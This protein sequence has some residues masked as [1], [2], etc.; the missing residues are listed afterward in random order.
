ML[1][2]HTNVR[3]L[4]WH[5]YTQ[6]YYLNFFQGQRKNSTLGAYEMDRL[7]AYFSYV[8]TCLSQQLGQLDMWKDA[9]NVISR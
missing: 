1:C 3:W 5:Y 4:Y 8:K 6:N 2:S 9:G 7:Y